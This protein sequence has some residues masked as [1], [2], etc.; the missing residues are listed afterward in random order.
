MRPYRFYLL[1]EHDHIVRAYEAEL[2]DDAAAI[3]EARGIGH[4]NDVSIWQLDRHVGEF[5]PT[6][7]QL[8]V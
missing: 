6:S 3:Q 7:M 2:A 4:P 8:R 1:D 5:D